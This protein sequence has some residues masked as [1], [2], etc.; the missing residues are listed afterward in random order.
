MTAP[1]LCHF[2]NEFCA[3]L[4]RER[5]AL[6]MSWHYLKSTKPRQFHMSWVRALGRN[7]YN[8]DD[9]IGYST[10]YSMLQNR[11]YSTLLKDGGIIQVS[12]DY[13]G[14][15]LVGHRYTYLPCPIYFD[16]ADL[17]LVDEEIPFIEL[18]DELRHKELVNRFRI[19]PSFRF[20]YDPSSTQDDH[21]LSHV[22]IGK[23]SSRIPVSC[24]IRVE[25]FFRFVFKNFYPSE[26]TRYS[27]LNEL[28]SQVL[29][30]TITEEEK[31]ELHMHVC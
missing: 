21:P 13:S 9:D 29:P 3:F 16:E 22:H 18:I 6:G 11:D 4:M 24:P 26:F 27:K 1:T 28:S 10:Y 14:N 30:E 12:L 19:R 23:S 17:G 5:L 2:V 15:D 31:S 25:Q 8:R 7:S 20:E